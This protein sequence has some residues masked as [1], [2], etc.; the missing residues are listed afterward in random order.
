D[1][2]VPFLDAI[3]AASG[4]PILYVSHDLAEIARL[5]QRI[6]VLNQGR[7][8]ASG[9]IED[10]LSDPAVVPFVGLRDAGAVLAGR[11]VGRADDGLTKLETPAG[12]LWVPDVA[13]APGSVARVRIPAQ[14][15]IL[16]LHEPQNMSALNVLSVTVEQISSTG[17][18]VMVGLK[19]GEA[20]VLARITERSAKAM[21]LSSGDAIY[22]IVK[23]TAISSELS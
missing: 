7:A 9:P 13:G 8:V 5:A 14:D 16:S 22:A 21:G 6:V 19:A 12:A 1:D 2:V 20:R 23:T 10:V 17:T 3:R 18:G 4:I 11:I 15:V